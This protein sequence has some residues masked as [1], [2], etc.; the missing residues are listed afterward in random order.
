MPTPLAA[1]NYLILDSGSAL[2]RGNGPLVVSKRRIW[3]DELH[4]AVIAI[5]VRIPLQTF[6]SASSGLRRR[7][8]VNTSSPISRRQYC[9]AKLTPV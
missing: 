8:S 6:Y 2:G 3:P 4:D 1:T 9:Q 7:K 5:P